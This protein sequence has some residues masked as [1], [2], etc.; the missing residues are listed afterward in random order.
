MVEKHLIHKQSS[1]SQEKVI[2]ND[3]SQVKDLE[4]FLM[5]S[6]SYASRSVV[7]PLFVHCFKVSLSKYRP[8]LTELEFNIH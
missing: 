3:M 6:S 2:N 5:S 4:L 8:P 1:R 7:S